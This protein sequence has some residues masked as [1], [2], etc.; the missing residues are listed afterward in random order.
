[1]QKGL[2]FDTKRFSIHDGPGIRTTVFLKGCPLRCA[3]CHNP[4]SQDTDPGVMLRPGRC[5]ACGACVEVC[6]EHAIA[7]N[8]SGAVVTDLDRCVR[9]ATCTETCYAEARQ[10]VGDERSVDE[11]MTEILADLSFYDESGGGVTLSGG[12]PLLQKDFAR[13]ILQACRMREIRTA[14]DT[15]GAVSWA[16]F[17]Q[18]RPYTDLFLYDLKHIDDGEHRRHTGAG[19]R[20]ILENLRKLAACGADV[21]LR[22]A[23][24]PG[25]NDGDRQVDEIGAFAAAL[26]R[27]YPVTV[28][29]YHAAAEEKYRRLN[30]PW[31]LAD[32]QP[33]TKER[34]AEI[35]G[36]LGA[37]GLEV[38]TGG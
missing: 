16:A 34:M 29:P 6:P 35:A 3:W 19:N 7:R 8:G 25:F 27:R 4:E 21:V 2:V 17:E 22:I 23:I 5:I 26:P 12:E 32:V 33:P 10:R 13:A 11:V 15:S 30:M 9:C 28:L 38:T 14:V 1:M 36:L 31:S 37:R 24:I 20:R 18:V